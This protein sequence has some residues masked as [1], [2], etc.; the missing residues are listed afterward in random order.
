VADDSANHHIMIIFN[1][2]IDRKIL[3]KDIPENKPKY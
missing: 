2:E 1:Y 3:I